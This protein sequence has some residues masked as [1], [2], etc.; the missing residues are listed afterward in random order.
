MPLRSTIRS[1]GL[2][3]VRIGHRKAG[4]SSRRLVDEVGVDVFRLKSPELPVGFVAPAQESAD[5]PAPLL[6][7]R[8]REAALIAHP[9]HILVELALALKHDSW[10]TPRN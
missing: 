10:F 5:Y 9:Y 6:H 1:S 4:P 3:A 7:R 8:W 2:F